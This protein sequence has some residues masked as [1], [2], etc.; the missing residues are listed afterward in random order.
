MQSASLEDHFKGALFYYVG[1]ITFDIFGI[2]TKV[3]YENMWR[4][5]FCYL[6]KAHVSGLERLVSVKGLKQYL[7]KNFS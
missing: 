3:A 1:N 6:C 5:P 7:R 2:S 4:S